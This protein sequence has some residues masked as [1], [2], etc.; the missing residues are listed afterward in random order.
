MKY[1]VLAESE[2]YYDLAVMASPRVSQVDGEKVRQAFVS[3]TR[4]P[5]GQR[6]LQLAAQSLEQTKAR[7]FV[8]VD[9]RDYR[10]YRN[11]FKHTLVP[12]NE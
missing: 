7:G 5:E 8:A 10:N 12:V 1:R 4:D 3:M 2:P 6:V 11:F 9:D